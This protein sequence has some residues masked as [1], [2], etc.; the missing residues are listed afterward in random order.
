M[1]PTAPAALTE[2]RTGRN[3]PQWRRLDKFNKFP[4]QIRAFIA[5]FSDTTDILGSGKRDK[6]GLPVNAAK[7]CAAKRHLFNTYYLSHSGPAR[8]ERIL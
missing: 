1:L 6:T 5:P 2:Y 8:K 4:F 7:A 3:R